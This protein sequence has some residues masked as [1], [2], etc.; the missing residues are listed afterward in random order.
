MHLEVDGE[1]TIH[2]ASETSAK[3][4]VHDHSG[5]EYQGVAD[6]FSMGT[7]CINLLPSFKDSTYAILSANLMENVQVFPGDRWG[8]G[9]SKGS[10]TTFFDPTGG[11]IGSY[12]CDIFGTQRV[13]LM[14]K[15]AAQWLLLWQMTMLK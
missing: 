8:E 6:M 4:G 11:G 1:T 2:F 12:Y 10:Q 15:T 13:N 5:D 9:C 14:H 3:S 7:K